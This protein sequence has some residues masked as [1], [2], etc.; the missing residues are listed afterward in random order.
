MNTLTRTTNINKKNLLSQNPVM[1]RLSKVEEKSSEHVTY[2]GVAKKCGFFVLMIIA[3]IAI[4]FLTSILCGMTN[5]NNADYPMPFIVLMGVAA[6]ATLITPFIAIFS[7]KC[8]AVAGSI[9]CASIGIVYTSSALFVESYRNEILLALFVTIALFIALTLLF[10]MNIIKVTQKFR[11]TAYIAL[12]AF[13][14]T[15][16]LLVVSLFIPAL[17]GPVTAI[18][19]NPLICIGISVISVIVASAFVLMDLQN[20]RDAV[21][22][23]I[24]KSYEWYGA[25]GIIFSVIWLFAEVLQLISSAKNA[26]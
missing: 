16:I 14:I 26:L 19:S 8:T 2:Q 11:S 6:L 4:T 25:F 18:M 10:A 17:S 23:Q 21:D 24:P 13:L 1:K 22:N 3:G 9:F 20:I 7:K 12:S 15:G 5:G